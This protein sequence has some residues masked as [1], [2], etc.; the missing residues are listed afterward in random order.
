MLNEFT[1]LFAQCLEDVINYEE[2]VGGIILDASKPPGSAV[3][4]SGGGQQPIRT[5]DAFHFWPHSAHTVTP[6]HAEVMR[7]KAHL[8]IRM[9]ELRIGQQLLIQVKQKH[10][11]TKK[12]KEKKRKIHLK[13]RENEIHQFPHRR[14]IFRCLTSNCHWPCKRHSRSAKLINGGLC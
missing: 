13:L 6:R 10:K 9:L 7:K 14:Y 2:E 11:Q 4:T 5:P 3:P 8:V 12:R 1:A